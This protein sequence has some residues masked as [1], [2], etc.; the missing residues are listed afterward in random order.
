[1]SRHL[2]QNLKVRREGYDILVEVREALNCRMADAVARGWPRCPRCGGALIQ[3]AGG[4]ACARCGAEYD[5]A[6]RRR[7]PSYV[8]DLYA[9]E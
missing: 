2:Y 5:L 8:E 3:G 9:E 1:M 4:L 7:P 6:P